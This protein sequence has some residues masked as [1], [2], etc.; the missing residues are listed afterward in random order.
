MQTGLNTDETILLIKK[1]IAY[2]D[3]CNEYFYESTAIDAAKDARH[4]YDW[5]TASGYPKKIAK[6]IADA[7]YDTEMEPYTAK[8]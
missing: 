7:V 3:Y 6:A 2:N 8:K 1:R 4:A 5:A